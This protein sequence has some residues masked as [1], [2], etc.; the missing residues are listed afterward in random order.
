MDSHEIIGLLNEDVRDEHGAIILYL[1]LAYALG[2]GELGAEV[3]A[4]AREEMRHFKWLSEEVVRLGGLPATDRANVGAGETEP[5]AMMRAAIAAEEEAA[6]TYE[7]HAKAVGVPS[8]AGLLRRIAVDERAHLATFQKL[9]AKLEAAAPEAGAPAEPPA[10]AAA[11]VPAEALQQDVALEYTTLLQYL[12]QSFLTPHCGLSK[13]LLD[14]AVV[15]MTHMGWIAEYLAEQGIPPVLEHGAVDTNPDPE[16]ILQANIQTEVDVEEAYRRQLAAAQDPGLR[17]L[18]QRV[19]DHSEY[20]EVHFR[21]LLSGL[22]AEREP[23]ARTA[24]GWTVGSLLGRK[25]E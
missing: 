19:L 16:H 22:Q 1:R 18:L 10:E 12:Q 5:A 20:H 21:E 8:I 6:A 2:E 4:I 9:L 15:E 14:Q 11:Q 7:A 3:E 23:A 13:D 25:Q 17:A 24:T